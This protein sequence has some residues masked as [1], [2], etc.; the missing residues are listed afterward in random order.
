[1]QGIIIVR[2]GKL[3]GAI[4]YYNRDDVLH[5]WSYD[6]DDATV[7]GEQSA[8]PQF[9]DNNF[10]RYEHKLVTSKDD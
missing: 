10:F 5:P 8:I 1:M 4:T 2:I 7:F 3:T 9:Q 6:S